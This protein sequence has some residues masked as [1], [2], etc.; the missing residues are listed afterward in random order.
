MPPKN[1][2]GKQPVRNDPGVGSSSS[3]RGGPQTQSASRPKKTWPKINRLSNPTQARLLRIIL[4]EDETTAQQRAV[5]LRRLNG[6]K[7]DVISAGKGE[8]DDSMDTKIA[9][10]EEAVA[11][12][13][14]NEREAMIEALILQDE[15]DSGT[16]AMASPPLS[17]A[18]AQ[19]VDPFPNFR[20]KD[21]DDLGSRLERFDGAG[22]T[23]NS[24]N[25]AAAA[26]RSNQERPDSRP[27]VQNSNTSN[28]RPPQGSSGRVVP[29]GPSDRQPGNQSNAPTQPSREGR[30]GSPITGT[31]SQSQPGSRPN[32]QIPRPGATANTGN[33]SQS[34]PGSRPNAQI[35]R[36]GA[37]AATISAPAP[38]STQNRSG[39]A[40]PPPPLGTAQPA[41]VQNVQAR[42]QTAQANI[43]IPT[44][45]A[46]DLPNTQTQGSGTAYIPA[47]PGGVTGLE[48]PQSHSQ[49]STAGPRSSNVESQNQSFGAALSADDI[50]RIQRHGQSSAA[51]PA[52]AAPPIAATQPIAEQSLNQASPAAAAPPAAATQPIAEQSPYQASPAADSDIELTDVPHQRPA[53]RPAH[54]GAAEIL[55]A[56]DRRRSRSP[57]P[58]NVPRSNV[59]VRN[60]SPRQSPPRVLPPHDAPQNERSHD[61]GSTGEPG[62][63]NAQINQ[64]HVPTLDQQ[65]V[66]GYEANNSTG[67]QGGEVVLG[68]HELMSIDNFDGSND[69]GST[70]RLDEV[71]DYDHEHDLFPVEANDYDY[72]HELLRDEE[73]LVPVHRPGLSNEAEPLVEYP[74]LGDQVTNEQGDTVQMGAEH[75]EPLVEYPLLG[76]QMTN[77]QGDTVQMDAEHTGALSPGNIDAEVEESPDAGAPGST[78]PNEEY[79]ANFGDDSR[80]PDRDS[81]GESD[82]SPEDHQR[83]VHPDA[84]MK[85]K[86]FRTI[87]G[88]GKQV[89]VQYGPDNAATY[90]LEP[91][92][93]TQCIWAPGQNGVLDIS[94]EHRQNP[95]GKKAKIVWVAWLVKEGTGNPVE[96]LDPSRRQPPNQR[97]GQVVVKLKWV[98]NGEKTLEF[99]TVTRASFTGRDK[100][101]DE[102]IYLRAGHQQNKYTQWLAATYPRLRGESPDEFVRRIQEGAIAARKEPVLPA[103]FRRPRQAAVEPRRRRQSIVESPQTA[104]PTL[105][106]NEREEAEDYWNYRNLWRVDNHVDG[107][108]RLTRAQSAQLEEDWQ[109]HKDVSGENR[110]GLRAVRDGHA[111]Y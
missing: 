5:K 16:D 92:S 108:Q 93:T 56:R 95:R 31:A 106:L 103:F 80:P 37:T 28:A 51:S 67:G 45:A 30:N 109:A 44:T 72:E 26:T 88:G 83:I 35:P 7:A 15:T 39:A 81:D 60:S 91:N 41:S 33:T 63:E 55:D 75:T 34:Q 62:A 100:D 84:V 19:P 2:K 48:P 36:P 82:F 53:Y 85:L 32:A 71:N 17:P 77:E 54:A 21:F 111:V 52:A 18:P 87:G 1:G 110:G 43:P 57:G 40:R 86:A 50:S 38:P 102:A 9:Q 78:E 27:A 64:G 8:T 3:T 68:S 65:H 12:D 22:N 11:V 90:R 70:D 46:A 24:T 42:S 23:N 6:I 47:T 79:G 99:R 25:A 58:S 94:K 76:D 98:D 73:D 96:S 20:L 14:R 89:V 13:D 97:F 61:Q 49:T 59:R 10:L 66:A 74:L 4:K 105:D 104:R 29:A 107:N 101:A 69:L